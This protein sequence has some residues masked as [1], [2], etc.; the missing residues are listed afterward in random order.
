[1]AGSELDSS[2]TMEMANSDVRVIM[3]PE[4]RSSTIKMPRL[5]E[6]VLTG[7]FMET[8]DASN[9]KSC[10]VTWMPEVAHVCRFWRQVALSYSQ[11]WTCINIEPRRHEHALHFIKLSKSLPLRLYMDTC[12]FYFHS[13]E[14]WDA[15]HQKSLMLLS[16]YMN[17]F[18]SI[19]LRFGSSHHKFIAQFSK[20][21]LEPAPFLERLEFY[22]INELDDDDHFFT[23]PWPNDPFIESAPRLTDVTMDGSLVTNWGSI[24]FDLLRLRI[25]NPNEMH[26][27]KRST[28]TSRSTLTCRYSAKSRWRI[29]LSGLRPKFFTP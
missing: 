24:F 12:P 16:S 6:E 14:E 29:S 18:S 2:R 13:H 23:L 10:D 22:H 5:P 25:H 20:A 4:S 21:L 28:L 26:I 7:I 1:M 19:K 9:G 8:Y 17:R 27:S 11:L 3:I 15:F